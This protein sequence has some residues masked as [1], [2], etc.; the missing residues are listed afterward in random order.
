M[1]LSAW[2]DPASSTQPWFPAIWSSL[3]QLG[4]G[5]IVWLS[6]SKV[7]WQVSGDGTAASGRW[8]DAPRFIYFLKPSTLSAL[9]AL[10]L[11]TPRSTTILVK[12]LSHTQ[13]RADS[14]TSYSSA[15]LS[16][17]NQTLGSLRAYL[18]HISSISS[19][20]N[21]NVYLTAS[22]ENTWIVTW[23]QTHEQSLG[24]IPSPPIND[25]P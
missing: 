4:Q 10:C 16:A 11:A 23:A 18:L 17:P 21:I 3:T 22:S 8:L 20:G 24:F 14:E 9:M 19:K 12:H 15:C 7:R 5:M 1:W 6:V 25:L 2:G 13:S